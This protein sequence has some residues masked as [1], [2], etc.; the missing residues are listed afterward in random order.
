[1]GL[2]VRKGSIFRNE[3]MQLNSFDGFQVKNKT[4][5]SLAEGRI[6]SHV[7]EADIET[8][9]SYDEIGRQISITVSPG[10]IYEATETHEHSLLSDTAGY[11]LT[12]TD[13]KGVKTR[14]TTDGLRGFVR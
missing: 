6:A 10:T 5:Y 14:S 8:Q 13:A 11:T 4:N 1:M 3:T 7:D 9:F 12:I 2:L